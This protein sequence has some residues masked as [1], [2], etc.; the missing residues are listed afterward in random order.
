MFRCDRWRR[1]FFEAP[2]S[3]EKSWKSPFPLQ[4]GT[5]NDFRTGRHRT[6]LVCLLLAAG[7]LA[8]YWP[9]RHYGFVDYDDNDYV[10]NNPTVRAGLSWWGLAWAFVDQHASNWHPLTWLSLMLDCQ[11][12]GP[13]AGPIH[14]VNVLFH[15][16]NAVLLLLLL[17]SMTGAFWRSA[18]VAT[19]FAWHPLRVESVA[20]ISE[21][22]DV[23]SGF[24]FMLT[25]WMYVLHVKREVL[26]FPANADEKPWSKFTSA[27]PRLFF[28][29]LSAGFFV[30]GLL[31]KP[32]LVTVP[33]ILLL[34]DFWPLNRFVAADE[35]APAL[36][37]AK[38][39][40]AEKQPFFLFSAV[41]G[42]ITFFAQREGGATASG[43][44]LG[45]ASQMGGA[46]VGYWGYLEK[47]F[48]PRNLACLYLR[49]NHVNPGALAVAVLVLTGISILAATHLRTRPYLMMGW[50]WFLGMLLP[51]SGLI[52]FGLQSIADR[53]TYLP[54]IG[55]YVMCV[56][57]AAELAE[58]LF[59]PAARRLLPGAVAAAILAACALW[60]R[61][62]LG[63]WQNTQTLMEHALK[64]DP[65]NYV[66]HDDLGV[67]FSRIGRTQDALLQFQRERELEPNSAPPPA[68]S[69]HSSPA[70]AG[71]K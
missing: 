59:P 30:L 67:Y 47:L 8:I 45:I 48:W 61:H 71:S 64:I 26:P 2:F 28:Y 40:L 12:F 29:K 25:L 37:N 20:W 21:R 57:A 35:G 7:T 69:R 44:P 38:N 14:M 13:N 9:A 22:K 49:P 65:D 50:L 60:S 70:P 19:L 66:A 3:L 46:V 56:W 51:V 63:Y 58:A 41:I 5:V 6:W 18:V 23:L 39:L 42:V 27:S 17:N 62:Q 32:M 24:F 68:N 31:S 34:I 10:F 52:Q 16:A 54:S 1:T 15:C 53:Y 43:P 36:K 55:F 33:L 11:L 4:Y